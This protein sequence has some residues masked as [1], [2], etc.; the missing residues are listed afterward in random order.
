MY[1]RLLPVPWPAWV[2]SCAF[3]AAVCVVAFSGYVPKYVPAAYLVMSLVTFIKYYIDKKSA[4]DGSWRVSEKTL[5]LLEF[6]FGWPGALIAQW[7]LHHKNRK[8]EYQVLFWFIVI[9]HMVSIGAAVQ[10]K[11]SWRYAFR[12]PGN[13]STGTVRSGRQG[14]TVEW[15]AGR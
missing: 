2:L 1:R 7:Q 4:E 10:Q 3:L 6:A 11:G 15:S 9:V 13:K 8:G 5:H 12:H 14:I